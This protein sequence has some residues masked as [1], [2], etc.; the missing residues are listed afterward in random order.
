M[1]PQVY[2]TRRKKI[3]MRMFLLPIVVLLSLTWA[4]CSSSDENPD[5]RKPEPTLLSE[6][7]PS[8]VRANVIGISVSGSSGSYS[9]QVTVESD[10]TG[11]GQYA[12]WWEVLSPEGRLI[13]RRVLLHSHDTE[14]PFTRSG[15]PVGIQ[16][17]ETVIVRAHMNIVGYEGVA[18]RGSAE[19]G[20][21][22]AELPDRF[23]ENVSKQEPQPLGCA[24]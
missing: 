20:F 3:K 13:Y 7:T 16:P 21:E 11:C 1:K 10:E 4:A 23:A 24:F 22:V 5:S 14:Q 6:S 18:Y 17:E 12:D 9:F 8:M 15:G 19:G 2:T